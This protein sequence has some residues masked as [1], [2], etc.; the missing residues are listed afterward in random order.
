MVTALGNIT[1]LAATT[2]K[3]LA[4]LLKPSVARFL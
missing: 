2:P 1:P 4:L 3:S